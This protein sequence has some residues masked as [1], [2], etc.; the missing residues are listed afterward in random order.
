MKDR[1]ITSVRE[2]LHPLQNM[3][4][5]LCFI[6]SSLLNLT[7]FY[8]GLAYEDNVIRKCGF[9]LGCVLFAVL[10]GL[11]LLS[12]LRTHRLSLRTWVLLGSVM[13][14]FILCYGIAFW[15]F[16]LHSSLVSNVEKFIVFCVPAFFAG[17]CGAM[18]KGE[19]A[20]FSTLESVSFLAFPGALIYANS[21]IFDCLPWNYGA[22]LG[23]LN[24]M[25]LA[26]TFMPFL[27]AHLICFSEG[28]EWTIPFTKK[29]V[30]RPQL[31]RCVFIGFYWVAI[32]ASATRG[33]YV[34][35]IGF[36]VL[37]AISKLIHREKA[38]KPVCLVSVAMVGLLLF[39]LFIYAPP[40]L[41]R[42]SRVNIFL[43][44]LKEGE[45][46]TT[47]EDASVA[48]HIDDLVQADGG[49]QVTNR[50]VTPTQPTEPGNSEDD[51]TSE[52]LQIRS[53]GT[54]FKLAVKEFLKAPLFGLGPTGY[55]VKYGMYPHTAVL[56]LLC[57]TGI[58]GTFVFLSLLFYTIIRLVL[59]GWK[60]KDI[61]HLLLFFVAYA[62]QANISGSIW[63]CPALLCALGYGIAISLPGMQ[64]AY[65]EGKHSLETK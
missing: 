36:C 9:M 51:I 46:V 53:R 29:S 39:N 45:L 23:I 2:R 8:L 16:G 5:P 47:N 4:F 1:K 14:F 24:Y 25:T 56:E 10:C 37:L 62:V 33:A 30:K 6:F 63:N 59:A 31:L 55:S 32:I 48:E 21:V 22:D 17:I 20:F 44:G 27:L 61:R 49:Q 26:Y 41:Y 3:L 38:A 60:H 34:C 57:E 13:L 18:Q 15:K 65:Q 50:P 40:G 28:A 11:T 58:I 54:L 7:F 12:T 64:P 42:L 43:N 19:K 52:N 35:V